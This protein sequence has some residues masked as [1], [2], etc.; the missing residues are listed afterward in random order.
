MSNLLIAS[1]LK[2]LR[3]SYNYTILDAA[4]LLG[5]SK[6]SISKWESGDY[7]AIEHLYGLS[8]VYN[9]SVSEL[10]SGKL[11]SEENTLFWKRNYELSNYELKEKITNQNVEQLK[12]FYEHCNIVKK[13][14]F[15]LISKWA[16][17]QLNTFEIE[18]FEYIR[19]YFE[20]D[21]KYYSYKKG[22]VIVGINEKNKK[23][24]VIE[25]L[26]K[27]KNENKKSAN[28]EMRKIFNFIYDRKIDEVCDS[29]NLKAFEYMLSTFSQI[30]KDLLLYTN[31][32]IQEEEEIENPFG[33]KCKKI[34][35]RYRTN[36]E[37][38]EIPFFKVLINSGANC[39]FED[40]KIQS[41]WDDEMINEIEG[42]KKEIGADVYSK[43]NF[44]NFSGHTNVPVLNNWKMF[45]YNEYLSFINKSET[46][47]LRDIVN[48]KDSNP[49]KYYENL[50]RR[51]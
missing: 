19:K 7:I 37:I 6:A 34:V 48:I 9:V 14:F 31:L 16:N 26:E 36:Q 44:A 22:K 38:E 47:S 42:E 1:L 18:E 32:H 41:I 4:N 25:V 29:L 10:L 28:W 11:N 21:I 43:Y 35:Y 17:N 2:G 20:F 12:D 49:L 24:F 23:D 5:V 40:K 33:G 39:L 51:G 50:V 46:E 15:D 27:E 3:N 8:K 45:S 13:R 30:E